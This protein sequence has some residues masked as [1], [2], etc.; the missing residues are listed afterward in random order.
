MNQ[1]VWGKLINY[2]YEMD[3]CSGHRDPKKARERR[4]TR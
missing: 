1:E 4:K 2:L 3:S